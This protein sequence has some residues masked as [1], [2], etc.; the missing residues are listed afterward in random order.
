MAPLMSEARRPRNDLA[1]QELKGASRPAIHDAGVA[2]AAGLK[3]A[4]IH[5]TTHMTQFQPLLHERFGSR[6]WEETGALALLFHEPVAHR[7]PVVAYVGDKIEGAA[8]VPVWMERVRDGTRVLSGTASVGRLDPNVRD[9]SAVRRAL[10]KAIARPSPSVPLA[11]VRVQVGETSVRESGVALRFDGANI[12]PLFPY[13]YRDKLTRLTEPHPWFTREG[14][15]ASPWGRP[16]LPL[17][18]HNVLMCVSGVSEVP[19]RIATRT[20]LTFTL[21]LPLAGATP[22][23]ASNGAAAAF[24]TRAP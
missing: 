14:G 6:E 22:S 1:L 19:F 8:H 18:M 5:G 15:R 11:I 13:A 10:A 9:D 12:G 2:K 23:T 17:E 20:E 21:P 24:S 3:D 16:V 4:P 7:E